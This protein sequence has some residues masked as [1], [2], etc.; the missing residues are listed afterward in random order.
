[1]AIYIPRHFA[2][3]DL[4]VARE[5]VKL[6]PFATL[7]ST[8]GEEPWITHAP[9]SWDEEADYLR[10]H[11][12]RANP[13][14]RLLEEGCPTIAI[15]HGPH[16]YVSPTMYVTPEQVPTWNYAIAHFHVTPMIMTIEESVVELTRLVGAFDPDLTMN[17]GHVARQAPA[18]VAFRLQI[19]RVEI[20][21]KL[22]QNKPM[23]DRQGVIRGLR[24]RSDFASHLTADWMEKLIR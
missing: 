14:A 23:E 10:G 19:Q 7:I 22:S 6:E 16:T 5:I 12:A 15:F 13:H 1:M 17:E 3:D 24:E 2:C 9:L 4:Q 8:S 20:K 11:I 18:V 21:L